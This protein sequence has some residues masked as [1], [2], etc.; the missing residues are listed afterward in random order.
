LKKC[1][2]PVQGSH[3]VVS[4]HSV[5]EMC[6]WQMNGCLLF[7]GTFAFLGVSVVG[8]CNQQHTA[9]LS[10]SSSFTATNWSKQNTGIFYQLSSSTT[11]IFKISWPL[12][13]KSPRPS[14][15]RKPPNTTASY[16]RTP[17]SSV[18]LWFKA[19]TPVVGCTCHTSFGKSRGN[20]NFKSRPQ[21][22]TSV[23]ILYICAALTSCDDPR[24]TVTCCASVWL[25]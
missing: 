9:F 12:K 14:Q 10:P 24:K 3:G 25:Q 2:D 22:L 6:L 17:G 1:F 8:P 20:R 23:H 7:E 18:A 11:L 15:R 19:E 4:E 5:P 13:M 16:S 21:R